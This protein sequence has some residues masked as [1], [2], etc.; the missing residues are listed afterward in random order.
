MESLLQIESLT[1]SYG[2]RLL[3]GDITFGV[4]EGDK[5]GIIAK[6]GTGKTTLLNII[7]GKE[8]HDDG[9]VTFRK[10]IR[11]GHLEQSP[12]LNPNM[13][14]MEVCMSSYDKNDE[15]AWEY[16]LEKAEEY[17][18]DTDLFYQYYLA[19]HYNL[20]LLSHIYLLYHRTKNLL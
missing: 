16:E 3:F 10:D 5:I 4:N 19:F 17:F 7:C 13:T 18:S 12:L 8:A 2:D 20:H 11:V 1:K 14:V 6:N 9:K 15:N